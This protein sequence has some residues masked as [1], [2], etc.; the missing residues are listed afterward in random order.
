MATI[1]G[2]KFAYSHSTDWGVLMPHMQLEWEREFKDDPQS[3][4]A[5]FIYDPTGT[6]ISVTGDPEDKSYF[7]IGLGL[8]MILSR[9]RSGFIY[10]EKML[11]RDRLDQENL[12]LGL[13][14]EF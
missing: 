11:G 7:R 4:Q 6:P 3:I 14:M 9:G 12:S 8:S 10:Y 13:R 5:S 2:S 1:I